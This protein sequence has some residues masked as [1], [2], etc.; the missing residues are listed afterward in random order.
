[1]LLESLIGVFNATQASGE[2]IPTLAVGARYRVTSDIDLGAAWQFPLADGPGTRVI[3]NRV[4]A[5]MI[6][7]FSL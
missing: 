4:T 5:D 3:D 6:Y 7:R 1:M 2:T